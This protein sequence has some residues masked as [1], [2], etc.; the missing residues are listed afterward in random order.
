MAELSGFGYRAGTS[1]VHRLDVRVKMLCVA[2]MGIAGL[3]AAPKSLA[4]LTVLLVWTARTV[5]LPFSSIAS[6][7]R[8]AWLLLAVVF[9]ARAVSTPGTPLWTVSVLTISRE[10]VQQGAWVCWRLA[11]VFAAGLYFVHTTRPAEIKA[12]VEWMLRPVPW[13]PERRVAVM[14][15]LIVRF[16]PVIFYQARAT[17]E[18]QRA[19]CAESRKNPLIRLVRLIVPLIRRIFEHA[20]RL[21]VAMEARAYSEHRTGSHLSASLSDGLALGL[22]IGVLALSLVAYNHDGMPSGVT[23]ERPRP[24]LT[25]GID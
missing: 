24:C 7:F 6:E 9:A 16:I 20:D 1:F 4:V 10:G 23:V 21:A 12:A 11:L 13:I 15:S 25:L 3:G 18:A 8:Y 14:L 17:A 5:R 2:L 19:R 22:V